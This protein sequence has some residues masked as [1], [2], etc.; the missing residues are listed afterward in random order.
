MGYPS[1][2]R[3]PPERLIKARPNGRNP[4]LI[5]Y[6]RERIQLL[7]QPLGRRCLALGAPE[8]DAALPGGGLPI[9]GLH[10]IE[11]QGG[12]AGLGFCAALLVRLLKHDPRTVLWCRSAFPR[13]SELYGP[14]LVSFGL[15]P[16]R[17]LLV[18]PR[19]EADGLWVLQEALRSGAL[20]GVV[21]EARRLGASEARRLQL[22]AE[23]GGCAGFL[24]RRSCDPQTLA[25]LTRWRV[26][27]A[28]SSSALG[29]VEGL[30]WHV[31]L[32]RA[33]AGC[34]GC[35]VLEWRHETGNFAVV[36]P[37]S[38]RSSWGGEG[39]DRPPWLPRRGN[40][41]HGASR[42]AHG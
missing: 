22:A 5:K 36:A 21:G 12:G 33:R 1:L 10:E 34:P 17:L 38:H 39:A 25:A 4:S 26:S 31:E 16:S 23:A 24:L 14:G 8:L 2:E 42:A 41:A 9:P 20:A 37:L 13:R 6:L 11:A 35:W 7:E 32:V 40:E 29:G 30:R 3:P 27:S 28:P 18:R 19:R 15:P